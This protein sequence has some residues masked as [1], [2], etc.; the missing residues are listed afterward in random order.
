MGHPRFDSNPAGQDRHPLN[1]LRVRAG[2]PLRCISLA[3]NYV[4]VWLHYLNGSKLV[5]RGLP[6]CKG[7]LANFKPQW[8]GFL[9]VQEEE[10]KRGVALLAL[11][12]L[13]V[14]PLRAC[15][16]DNGIYGCR[17]ALRREGNRNNSPLSLLVY[18]R[19]DPE[20]VFTDLRV[21]QIVAQIHK[22]D[23]DD[24]GDMVFR[25]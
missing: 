13:C 21:R 12:P 20:I 3:E 22:V 1:I 6:D 18:G 23:L 2:T 14:R 16:T 9:P 25:A 11:T 15:M 7:C 24:N 5:C 10:P 8:E 17:L 4:G 19:A